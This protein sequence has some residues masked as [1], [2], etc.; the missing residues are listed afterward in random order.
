MKRYWLD[1]PANVTML[2]RGLWVI[3][4]F[5]ALLDLI[6]RRHDE[7]GFANWFGFFALYGFAACVAL[8]LAASP[9]L[10]TALIRPEANSHNC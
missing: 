1:D 4:T 2:Y 3:G 5:L 9:L 10:C 7:I 8:V 6:V